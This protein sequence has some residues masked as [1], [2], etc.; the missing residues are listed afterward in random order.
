MGPLFMSREREGQSESQ[1]EWGTCYQGLDW[2]DRLLELV[3]ER[4]RLDGGSGAFC[5]TALSG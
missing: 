3:A 4:L 5:W 1:T 2:L